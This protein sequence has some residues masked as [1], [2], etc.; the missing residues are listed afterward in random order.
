MQ[1]Y[2]ITAV[3]NSTLPASFEQWDINAEPAGN[4]E[5]VYANEALAYLQYRLAPLRRGLV[6]SLFCNVLGLAAL[7][8][9]A[10]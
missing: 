6:F 8:V 9:Q 1:R 5:F 7:A 2:E 4:G 3:P 10:W